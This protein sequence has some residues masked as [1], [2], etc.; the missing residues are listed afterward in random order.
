VQRSVGA[1]CSSGPVRHGWR[2]ALRAY[3]YGRSLRRVD[4]VAPLAQANRVDFRRGGVDEWYANGPL[5]IEQG[6]TLAARPRVS[7]NGPLTLS[8]ALSGNARRAVSRGST[9]VSFTA[10]GAALA[11]RGLGATDARGRRLPARMELREGNLLLRIE[12]HPRAAGPA[13]P[14]R[15]S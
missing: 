12:D 5:G 6:F 14:R 9:A 3:G 2:S 15:P 4:A 7:D 11:Y 1:A 8:L 13:R 10:P